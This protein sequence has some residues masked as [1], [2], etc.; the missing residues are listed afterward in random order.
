MLVFSDNIDPIP[1]FSN[2]CR[3]F[4]NSGISRTVRPMVLASAG[5]AASKEGVRKHRKVEV[6]KRR[7]WKIFMGRFGLSGVRKAEMDCMSFL[8]RRTFCY[9]GPPFELGVKLICRCEHLVE[10]MT[11]DPS[12]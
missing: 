8:K 9:E 12:L 7:G 11:H 10:S 2:N 1:V 6:A 3:K 5:F 4:D